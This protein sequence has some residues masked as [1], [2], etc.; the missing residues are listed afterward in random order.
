MTHLRIIVSG[1]VVL[2]GSVNFSSAA[3]NQH[4]YAT[5]TITSTSIGGGAISDNYSGGLGC[6]FETGSSNVLVSHLG[7]ISTNNITG[8]VTNHYVGVYGTGPGTPL[9]AQVIV[10]AG[11]SALYTN[12]FYWMPLDPPLLLSSNTSYIVA[13]MTYNGDGDWWGQQSSVTWNTWFVGSQGS[14]TRACEYG[15]GNTTWPVAGFTQSTANDTYVVPGLGYIEVGSAR[16]GVQTTNVAISAG[17]TV[18]VLGFATGQQPI[19][20]QWWEVGSPN[21]LLSTTTSDYAN[22]A[23]SNAASGNSGTYFLTASN[24]LGGEMSA[25]V[26]VT[27]TAIPVGI[28]Q[29]PT[30]LTVFA[31]YQA[32]FFTTAT[33]TPPISYQW[34]RNG[35]FIPGATSN[36]YS[37]FAYYPTNNGDVYACLASN[38]V[39]ST[40]YSI[41][42]SNAILTVLPNLAY[43][44]EFLHGYHTNLTQN[45]YSGTVGGQFTVGN[46]AVTVTHLGYYTPTN[47]YTTP[48]NCT[49]TL[50]HR[51]G[52]FDA[53]G[54]VLYGYVTVPSGS[55]PVINGYIWQPL[56]P[57]LV[58]SSNTTY[59]LVAEVTGGSD[60]WGD[61]YIVPDLNHYFANSCAASYGSAWPNPGINGL[62]A[63]QMYSAPNMAIL[64]LPQLSAFVTPTNLAQPLYSSAT[65][66]GIVAGQAPITI[67]WYQNGIPLAGQTNSTLFFSSLQDT[68]AGSYYIVATN[69]LTFA[70]VTSAVATVTV[71]KYPIIQ[72]QLPE[73]YTNSLNTNFLTL[74]AGANP[75]FSLSAIGIQPLYYQWFGNGVPVSGATNASYT[76]LNAQAGGATNL[77]CLVTNSAGSATSMV[78]TASVIPN[79]TNSAGGLAPYP[80]SV[81]A[82]NPIGYWRLNEVDDNNGQPGDGNPNALCH[83]YV[84]GNDGLYTNVNLGQQGYNP[85]T[86]PSDTSALFGENGNTLYDSHAYQIAGINFSSPTNTS[87]AFTVE[88]WV[89]GYQ[90]T[91]DAGIVT[92]GWGGGGEQFELDTGAD[93]GTPSH[94]FR[95][96]FRDSG[97]NL[98][99]V[100][101]SIVPNNTGGLPS[102]GTWYYLVG[103]VDEVN[104]NTAFYIN[105][106]NVGTTAISPG[107]GVL[108]STNLM[109][110]GS[111]M[112]TLNSNYNDQ[113][114]GY[115]NDVA[116]FN[117]A[118]NP[119]QVAS[120]YAVVGNLAP[121]LIPMPVTSTNVSANATLVIPVTAF[122]TGPL[123]YAWF[124]VNGGTN[125]ATGSTNG[126]ELN[127]GLTVNNV[128]GAWNGDS[129]QL[130]VSNAYGTTNI[131]VALAVNTN[132]PQITLNPQPSQQTLLTGQSC[133][134]TVGAVGALPLY[135]QWEFNGTNLTGATNATLNI[136]A[137]TGVNQGSYF[138]IVTNAFG[139]TNSATVS[140]TVNT[141]ITYVSVVPTNVLVT[142]FL[143][144]GTSLAWW[145]NVVGG[146][147]NRNEYA[148]LAFTHLKLNIVRYNI[149]CTENPDIV[150]TIQFRAQIPGYEPSNGMWDWNADTNQVWMLLQAVALGANHVEASSY[151]P[152]YWMTV[153]GSVTGSTN[154][155]SNN[156]QTGYENAFAFYLA[157]VI[158]NLTV[159]DGVTV[160]FITPMNEPS[161]SWSYGGN[162]PGCHMSAAQQSRVVVDLSSNLAALNLPVGIDAAEEI[163][164]STTLSSLDSYS[165]AGLNDVS[166]I[167]THTYGSSGLASLGSQ[168]AS[169]QKPVWTAEY[170]DSDATGLTM[171]RRI[172][173]DITGMSLQAWIYWQVCDYAGWGCISNS[174]NGSGDTSY[175][176]A[177]KFYVLG[178][179]SQF[180]SPG[181]QILKVGDNNSLAAYNA[182][183]NSLVIVTVN[184]S[185]NAYTAGFQL[186]GFSGLPAQASLYRTSLTE[187]QSPYSVSLTNTT[188]VAYIP[189]QSVSTFVLNLAPTITSQ[190]PVTYTNLFTLYA[191][192]SPTFLVTASGSP[193]LNYLWYTNGV[194]DGAATNASLTLAD[195]P[196]GFITNYCIV[197]N[198]TGSVTSTV[199]TASVI[200]DPTNAYPDTVL[201]NNP[202]A[203][204]RLN[205]SA[206]S[207]IAFDYAGG[208]NGIYGVNT[209]NGLPGVP[210]TG[211]TDELG[212]AMNDS[213]A[214]PGAGY[215]TNAG[216]ILN[217]NAVTFICWVF[218]FTNQNNPSGLVFCRS[219]STVSGSQ[220]GGGNAFD[221]TWNGLASTYDYGS[222]LTVPTNIWSLVALT[223]TSSNAVLYVFNANGWSS[224]TNSVPNAI[225]SFFGGFSLGADPQP[226]TLPGRIFNGEMDEVAVFN[227]PLSSSQLNQLFFAATNIVS[228]V[229]TTPTKIVFSVSANQ[230]T[231]SWPADHTGWQLQAQTNSLSVGISTNWVDV[232][233]SST[234]NQVIIPIGLTNGCVFYRLV[235]P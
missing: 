80:Q 42:S 74:Y 204:W 61:T 13:G 154:G 93:G 149:G 186:S 121:L 119:G 73:T 25:N 34:L 168:A 81:L 2:L 120:E 112:S 64:A 176:L 135:F 214:T 35:S 72:S 32:S 163:A 179:F 221:Y 58:L 187:N 197:T 155:T 107:I 142:N 38:V 125:V 71:Y 14:S 159:N 47:Q 39:G 191:G 138:V 23:I 20:N 134:Y 188:L 233:N 160:D 4:L 128:P 1:I 171:A 49:L 109:S 24:A 225:Q 218:P 167:T 130:T 65:L 185:A 29:Q 52:I 217:T 17:Q 126:V 219:G 196:V 53:S 178:Q 10:P 184:T 95:F 144:W 84:G 129:L 60:P 75:T 40:P 226:S 69:T 27:V 201:S 87:M 18:S 235:Y 100:N 92:L 131:L 41:T 111:R 189:A 202:I 51:V 105:G 103:V 141:N 101:S 158:S 44:Q 157:M 30:N 88:A 222:G 83:D 231:L 212:V 77:Y 192:V 48:T 33:G 181:S 89:N 99:S 198:S 206:G 115:V 36:S 200:A 230:L 70:S 113:F 213:V 153:S 203:Y 177:E 229:I 78:W 133:S 227:Y 26:T 90:Q 7:F 8:L 50:S 147:T 12:D 140:L 148:S 45:S 205:D 67:Q 21:I 68:D 127:A 152:P 170:G 82:L 210:T 85:T 183:S 220:I 174:L 143:G 234:T 63:N 193:P 190:L 195:V 86:D 172:H 37:L 54:K 97:E 106:V 55:N 199:W 15:P 161:G 31:N 9:L 132:A 151:S 62:Y 91:N 6:L 46:S 156:L 162:Q 117:H 123:T 207:S 110:I 122:G 211:F 215:V 57:P 180:I 66:T 114:Y 194:V 175:S 165:A 228:S 94:A 11:K 118:L 164:P 16:A 59:L 223:T 166:L 146:Y 28:S 3:Q 98:H 22:L 5:P 76:L 96:L 208:C 145:A 232:A 108:A 104:S 224:A 136:P 124:D 137:V 79:P 209:T 139:S 19:T 150:N 56:N 169:W 182:A 173:D 216:V 116:V 43:P 102:N